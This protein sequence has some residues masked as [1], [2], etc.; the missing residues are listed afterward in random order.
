MLFRSIWRTKDEITISNRQGGDGDH[1]IGN[2]PNQGIP[3]SAQE[4]CRKAEQDA[5]RHSQA[6]CNQTH[7]Q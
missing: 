7:A 1:G 3:P 6:G 4:A 5:N 2:G